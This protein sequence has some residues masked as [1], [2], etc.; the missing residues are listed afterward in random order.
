M[1]NVDFVIAKTHQTWFDNLKSKACNEVVFWTPS[2]W[3]IRE[4]IFGKPFYFIKRGH[5]SVLMGVGKFRSYALHK[6]S[7]AWNKY[8]YK[9]GADSLNDLMKL[10][11]RM[12]ATD[13][14]GCIELGDVEYW[15]PSNYLLYIEGK[16]LQKF[17]YC[18]ASK[19]DI[20]TLNVPEDF[21]LT[22]VSKKRQ[23]S[24]G[25]VVRLGQAA[26]KKLLMRE[27]G[28]CCVTGECQHE[29]LE[30]AHIQ[31]Y[32]SEKSHHIQNGLLLRCDIHK[33]FDS[34]LLIIDDDYCVRLSSK[35]TSQ[36]YECFRGQKIY[37]PSNQRSYPS[38]EALRE[39]SLQ[40][41]MVNMP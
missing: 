21:K 38:K 30:A 3:K 17:K 26:F 12:N 24:A 6:I 13:E 4:N 23:K 1:K 35:L 10:L 11:G 37:L 20:V 28:R 9:L 5:E 18:E 34:G 33:L 22:K 2:D 29:L 36:N 8:S 7:N 19:I 32:M 15:D 25:R 41:D 31:S 16:Y 27:Y 39:K 40:F 14:I